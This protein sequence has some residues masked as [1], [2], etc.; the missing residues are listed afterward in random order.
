MSSAAAFSPLEGE[1]AAKRPEGVGAAMRR[2]WSNGAAEE[3]PPEA[4]PSARF[5]G[6]SPSRGEDMQ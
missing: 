1:M 5:A 4:T 3:V 2:H 6:T